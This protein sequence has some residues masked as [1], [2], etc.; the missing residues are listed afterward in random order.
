MKK[1]EINKKTFIAKGTQ[2]TGDV[3]TEADASI[4]YNCVLRADI[5][6]ISVGK[7][8]NIQDGSVVHVDYDLPC[9]IGNDV[10]IGHNC[11]LHSC[12]IEDGCLIGM[13]AILLNGAHIK[14]GAVI[15]AGAIV[16]ENTIVEKN[17]LAVGVPAKTVKEIQDSYNKNLDH[18]KKYVTLSKKHAQG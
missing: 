7:R 10:T 5:S 4:W 11:I 12:I 8:T 13:G 9:I 3:R 18:A 1:P 6:K 15:G 16:K 2:I 14:K 17:M